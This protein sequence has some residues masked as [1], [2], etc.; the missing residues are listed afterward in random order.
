MALMLVGHGGLRRDAVCAGENGGR[1]E[2]KL[3]KS[4]GWQ[5]VIL[6]NAAE[7][8]GHATNAQTHASF[9]TRQT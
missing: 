3:H 1:R 5:R 2:E 7:T 9:A 4:S 6:V 8:N